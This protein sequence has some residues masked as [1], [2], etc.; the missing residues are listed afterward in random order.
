MSRITITR[1]GDQL[2]A[3]RHGIEPSEG[4]VVRWTREAIALKIAGHKYWSGHFM[5]RSYAP[6][7]IVVYTFRQEHVH[8]VSSGHWDIEQADELIYVEVGRDP[9]PV[10]VPKVY[11]NE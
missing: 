5:P 4:K 3:Q 2:V 6:P 8:R 7:S 9:D 10:R 1:E 11:D